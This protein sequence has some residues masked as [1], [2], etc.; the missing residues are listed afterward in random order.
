MTDLI[1]YHY[2]AS[3]APIRLLFL[4]SLTAYAYLFPPTELTKFTKPSPGDSLKNGLVF[5]WS[6]FELGVWFLI[7]I[8]LRDERKNIT[9]TRRED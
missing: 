2:W 5:T 7:Y 4:F 9:R 8:T 3:Q 6:F 1:A